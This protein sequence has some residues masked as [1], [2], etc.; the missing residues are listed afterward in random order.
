MAV[1]SSEKKR[2]EAEY[3][4]NVTTTSNTTSCSDQDPDQLTKI[5]QCHVGQGSSAINHHRPD[6]RT[7]VSATQPCRSLVDQH[8]IQQRMCHTNIKQINKFVSWLITGGSGGVTWGPDPPKIC[9]RSVG[10][11]KLGI[12]Y[13]PRS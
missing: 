2:H 6:S 11:P 13:T 9:R 10:A 8:S 3:A 4:A 5:R 12:G 1:S 7:S